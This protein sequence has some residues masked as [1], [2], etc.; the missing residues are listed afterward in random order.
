MIRLIKNILF[1]KSAYTGVIVAVFCIIFST[2]LNAKENLVT[3]TGTHVRVQVKSDDGHYVNTYLTFKGLVV[4]KMIK[5]DSVIR[6][7]IK[8]EPQKTNYDIILNSKDSKLSFDGKTNNGGGGNYYS[9]WKIWLSKYD[10]NYKNII[11]LRKKL[12]KNQVQVLRAIC[13]NLADEK[14]IKKYIGKNFANVNDPK[15][16][17]QNPDRIYKEFALIA[18]KCASGLK[19]VAPRSDDLSFVALKKPIANVALKKPIANC[20]MSALVT[21]R[22]QKTMKVMGLY[23]GQIDSKMGPGTVAGMKAAEVVISKRFGSQFHVK[24]DGCLTLAEI[25]WVEAL[26]EAKK[27]GFTC[28]NSQLTFEENEMYG[29]MLKDLG[30]LP[31]SHSFFRYSWTSALERE[32]L[33]GIIKFETSEQTTKTS[34]SGS[35]SVVFPFVRNCHLSVS[36]K[37]AL[38][39]IWLNGGKSTINLKSSSEAL[40]PSYT[41][42]MAQFFISDL[43]RFIETKGNLFGPDLVIKYSDVKSVSDTG[44]WD[45][46]RKNAFARLK[47]FVLKQDK[48]SEFHRVENKVRSERKQLGLARLKKALNNLLVDGMMY[49]GENAL[50]PQAVEVRKTIDDINAIK[51]RD[52]VPLLIE[53]INLVVQQFQSLKVPFREVEFEIDNLFLTDGQ[54]IALKKLKERNKREVELKEK[55]KER[56][57]L[58]AKA[59]EAERQIKLESAKRQAKLEEAKLQA[60]LEE[61]N[62]QAK[63][64][65]A[66]RQAK[67]EEARRQAELEE[68][69][70][71]VKLKAEKEKLTSLRLEAELTVEDIKEYIQS[72]GGFDI[73][74]PS[75]FQAVQGYEAKE[76]SKDL[77]SAYENLIAYTNKFDQFKVYRKD[78]AEKR[79]KKNLKLKIDLKEDVNRI[80]KE[81]ESWINGNPLA[82]EA[83]D[84]LVI[85]ESF[86][87]KDNT[88]NIKILEETLSELIAGIGQLGVDIPISELLDRRGYSLYGSNE[89]VSPVNVI[90]TLRDAQYYIKDSKEFIQQNPTVFGSKIIVLYNNIRSILENNDWSDEAQFSFNAYEEFTSREAAFVAFRKAVINDRAKGEQLA[91]KRLREAL[92]QLLADGTVYLQNNTLADNSLTVYKV[93]EYGRAFERNINPKDLISAID[94]IK[95][96]FRDNNVPFVDKLIATEFLEM[97]D[98]EIALVIKM[99]EETEA[100]TDEIQKETE[101]KRLRLKAELEKDELEKDEQEKEKLKI[102]DIW[103]PA[104][105]F[106]RK[107]KEYQEEAQ[108]LV[109]DARDY[110]KQGKTFP[111]E[112]VLLNA[113]VIDFKITD[114]NLQLFESYVKFRNYVLEFDEFKVFR[115][116]QVSIRSELAEEKRRLL[117]RELKLASDGLGKWLTKNQLDS[118]APLAVEVY[119]RLLDFDKEP[120][121][122]LSLKSFEQE[123]DLISVSIQELEIDSLYLPKS[124]N[125]PIDQPT[126]PTAGAPVKTSDKEDIISQIES[127]LLITDIQTYMK[128]GVGNFDTKLILLYGKVRPL[129]TGV[130]NASIEEAVLDLK[131]YVLSFNQFADYY[132]ERIISRRLDEE[133]EIKNIAMETISQYEAIFKWL[134]NNP[135]DQKATDIV[136]KLQSYEPKINILKIDLIDLERVALD[137]VYKGLSA[138]STRL[139]LSVL[140]NDEILL[141]ETSTSEIKKVSSSAQY[142]PKSLVVFV[143]LSGKASNVF[144]NING[145]IEFE[146][147]EANFCYEMVKPLSKIENFYTNVEI[148]KNLL[149]TFDQIKSCSADSILGT[150]ILVTDGLSLNEGNKKVASALKAGFEEVL[151]IDQQFFANSLM[152]DELISENLKTDI[153]DGIRA[154]F[155]YIVMQNNSQIGCLTLE[156]NLQAHKNFLKASGKRVAMLRDYPIATFE[157]MNLDNAFKQT[158]RQRCGLV[159]SDSES[160]EKLINGLDNFDIKYSLS[161]DWISSRKIKDK[162]AQID[163]EGTKASQEKSARQRELENQKK[164]EI[165]ALKKRLNAAKEKQARLRVMYGPRVRGL[166]DDAKPNIMSLLDGSFGLN[167]NKVSSQFDTAFPRLTGIVDY[168]FDRKWEEDKR[169]VDLVDYGVGRWLGRSVEIVDMSLVIDIKNRKIGKYKSLCFN[170]MYVWDDEFKVVRDPLATECSDENIRQTWLTKQSFESLWMVQVQ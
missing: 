46:D 20:K 58:E 148:K 136:L 45:L 117:K 158:Q 97:S 126:D 98:E 72:G 91:L 125:A 109:L 54:L 27:F 156:D 88:D 150:D 141:K 36:E 29:P 152:K 108:T 75:Y 61:L 39:A 122:L 143:N 17:L 133:I 85:L 116:E 119:R 12:P 5:G 68:A 74:F 50:K 30:F 154:G 134:Q 41:V 139:G 127:K 162:Q 159:Y 63:R 55:E 166:V 123:V 105:E 14:N 106:K 57:I 43:E 1:K 144:K 13:G 115:D 76:W 64:E 101:L 16:L 2:H 121:K 96:E 86:A 149:P 49:I 104:T 69:E 25:S 100:L 26:S 112:F 34:V 6:L 48:F 161:P 93:L 56:K 145:D 118:R 113:S 73:N 15:K 11:S 23:A 19:K 38:K 10:N 77:L 140:S 52:E 138:I 81:I 65:K 62:R 28:S 103:P 24:K 21:R 92:L 124:S 157:R 47:K 79:L 146:D 87:S 84:L 82:S 70:R 59:K 107:V 44:L 8:R 83:A 142:P 164:L 169:Q 22:A 32:L 60:I 9:G 53:K 131:N 31:Q 3:S 153:L 165:E 163:S 67:L 137:E 120:E 80:L 89:P 129:E 110:V 170:L 147:G 155:G 33:M 37:G 151:Q 66:E 4:G 102:I 78:K 168:H 111:L 99:N 114:W 95:R 71:Q 167:A 128:T 90:T 135:F 35:K 130:W 51:F 94:K 40:A 18:K 132:E 160:L 42:E 7:K